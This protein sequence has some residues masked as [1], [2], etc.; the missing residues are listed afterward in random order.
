MNVTRLMASLV[1]HEGLRLKVYD[2]AT[3]HPIGPGSTLIGHPTC[4]IGRALDTNGISEQEAYSLCTNDIDAR[5]RSLTSS[6]DFWDQL[7]DVRQNVLLEM[8]FQLGVG[9]L[10]DFRRMLAALR[11]RDWQAAAT[12]GLDSGWARQVPDRARTL[13]WML[14]SGAWE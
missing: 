2:D 12:A 1:T 4:G 8:A 10:L 3:G 5:V 9:G 6:L 14:A 11:A 13:M 7:D